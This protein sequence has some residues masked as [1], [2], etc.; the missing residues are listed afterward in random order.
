[1]VSEAEP[2]ST[3]S[4]SRG[5]SAISDRRVLREVRILTEVDLSWH[6]QFFPGSEKTPSV[7][8]G[9]CVLA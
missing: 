7:K 9:V 8:E 3:P 2:L 6:L 4:L 5:T 1:V